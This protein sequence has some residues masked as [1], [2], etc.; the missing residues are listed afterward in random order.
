MKKQCAFKP[1][2]CF[3]LALILCVSA[4]AGS[5]GASGTPAGDESGYQKLEPLK[6]ELSKEYLQ[7]LEDVEN[8]DA[9]K[10][11]SIIPE[12][13]KSPKI[14]SVMPQRSRAVT[15]IPASYDPRL[16]NDLTSVKDQG[17]V[18]AC[19][20]FS[21]NA[22]LEHLLRKTTGRIFDFS[23][24]HMRIYTSNIPQI[25]ALGKGYYDMSP[26]DGG[27]PW[28]TLPYLTTGKGAVLEAA[29]PYTPIERTTPWSTF[30][31]GTTQMNAESEKLVTDYI[32]IPLSDKAAVKQAIIDYGST[33]ISMW[34]GGGTTGNQG[35]FG[36]YYNAATGAF[37][38]NVYRNTN[39]ALAIV[40]WDDNYAVSNFGTH[41]PSAK[42][43]WLIKNSWG[44]SGTLANAG[45]YLWVSYQDYGI[46]GYYYVLNGNTWTG[47][48]ANESNT[49]TE[50]YAITKVRDTN[51]NRRVEYHD[52]LGPVGTVTLYTSAPTTAMAAVYS[53]NA[54]EKITDVMTHFNYSN[55]AYNIKIVSAPGGSIPSSTGS[56]GSVLASGT[57]SQPGLYTIP[58]NNPYVIPANG[59]YAII[60]TLTG[61]IVPSQVYPGYNE[62]YMSGEFSVTGSANSA[63]FTAAVGTGETFF[64]YGFGA[65]ADAWGDDMNLSLRA[66]VQGIASEPNSSASAS[67]TYTLGLDTPF[68]ISNPSGNKFSS[69]FHGGRVLKEIDDYTIN[70]NTI[71]VKSNYLWNINASW[72]VN[73][74]VNFNR[75]QSAVTKID[76]PRGNANGVG[77]IDAEDLVAIKKHLLDIGSSTAYQKLCMDVDGVNGITMV[78]LVMLK[79]QLVAMQ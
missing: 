57:S 79:K 11:G 19:W 31:W 30:T 1:F 34:A 27:N 25:K 38:N 17:Q 74:T 32:T 51:A 47:Y 48:P 49:E 65:W 45:G 66:I 50:V 29:V 2:F 16:N 5:I 23:E 14:Q 8:G 56:W 13:Y 4:G 43:A 22:V 3:F 58:L 52:A 36:T 12:P 18:G 78:D 7:Y 59:K 46:L 40:G 15:P 75:G 28:R 35:S 73:L 72:P 67:A 53:F 55:V 33:T 71:T 60:L 44:T 9:E 37:Y 39:H 20:A 68:T 70:G 10:Y 41:K 21:S 26:D 77:G 64:W 6:P 24:E 62:F 42:G 69:V 54:N 61:P 63:G 76:V